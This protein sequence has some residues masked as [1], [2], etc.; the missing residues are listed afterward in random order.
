MG[1]R[2]S[3]PTTP[4]SANYAERQRAIWY[5]LDL[6]GDGSERM[7][8]KVAVVC[9]LL[10]VNSEAQTTESCKIIHGR[11]RHYLNFG[12]VPGRRPGWGR[13]GGIEAPMYLIGHF[14][15][16]HVVDSPSWSGKDRWILGLQES[17]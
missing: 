4:F 14:C 5:A 6:L 8:L 9:L 17:L 13:E 16:R 1:C 2:A 10:T 12:K 7:I 15:S 3:L 11:A